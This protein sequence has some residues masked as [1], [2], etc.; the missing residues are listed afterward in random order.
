MAQFDELT[1]T[2][3]GNFGLVTAAQARHL[4]IRSKDIA[5]W[6]RLGRMERR[7]WGV[8]RI[9]H[10]APSPF[11][12]Y[13]EAVAIVGKGAVVFG[14]SVLARL[15][16]ALVN[17]LKVSVATERRVRR[18][19]P[20]WIRLVKFGKGEATENIEG[21]PCQ[22]LAGAIRICRG[23]VMAERLSEAAREAARKG[24]LG[25]DEAEALEKELAP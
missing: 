12:R 14:D 17:P 11:D 1:E 7:G 25:V 23:R 13:A 24:W 4:G 22:S 18:R 21:V 20:E 5:E 15:N 2:A 16:L 9:A 19:L 3:L 6:V 10:Y 8:Y